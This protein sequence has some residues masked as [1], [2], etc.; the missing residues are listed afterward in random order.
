MSCTACLAGS[1]SAEVGAA[2]CIEC[3]AGFFVAAN[4]SS[5]PC[6]ECASGSITDTGPHPLA[7][8]CTLCPV[9]EFSTASTVVCRA[10]PSGYRGASTRRSCEAC[11]AGT[12]QTTE[13]GIAC[14][15]T[16]CAPGTTGPFASTTASEAVCTDCP[17]GE[18]SKSTGSKTCTYCKRGQYVSTVG[19]SS[20]L[21]CET[22]NCSA[23]A[24]RMGCDSGG[25]EADAKCVG[26]CSPG[27]TKKDL[28]DL[29]DYVCEVWSTCTD[30]T[31][32]ACVKGKKIE[33]ISCNPCDPGKYSAFVDSDECNDCPTGR[34]TDRTAM[35]ECLLCV[36]GRIGNATSGQTSQSHCQICPVGLYQSNAGSNETSCKPCIAGKFGVGGSTNEM[37][38]GSCATGS[39][40]LA[41]SAACIAC[42]V[43][44]YGDKDT[45]T[46]S[47]EEH[48][49]PCEV[50]KYQN[51][52]GK[53]GCASCKPG[54]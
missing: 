14:S 1:Y 28:G 38:S 16:M 37:C 41:G 49:Q 21:R 48:C 39:Y 20:C 12:H 11:E 22:G 40:S 13:G 52:R 47:S 36:A 32:R 7:T 31:T 8:A 23:G 42:A 54:E 50:G 24:V 5:D 4:G 17:K 33:R 10:C 46:G 53:S 19:Q 3:T 18:Y 9:G 43:G 45:A 34:Y 2:V 25:A 35:S 51:E 27:Y 15:G 26:G 6:A 44:R 30:N 29:F